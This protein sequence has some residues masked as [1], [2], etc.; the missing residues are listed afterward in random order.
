M[1]MPAAPPSNNLSFSFTYLL[2]TTCLFQ[3]TASG[4]GCGI[5]RQFNFAL[6]LQQRLDKDMLPKCHGYL[7]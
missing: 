7:A 3:T 6:L 4:S 2:D 1:Y 5:A